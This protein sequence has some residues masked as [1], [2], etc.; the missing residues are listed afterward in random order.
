MSS[1]DPSGPHSASTTVDEVFEPPQIDDGRQLWRIARDSK[2]L[3]LN[4]PYSYV[5]W[6]RDFAATSV[7]ARADGEIRGFV[8]GFARPEEPGTLFVWQVA[9]DAAWRGRALAGRMLAYLA[10]GHRF[11]EATVTPDNTASDRLFSA[12]ARDSGADLR[13]TP[14]LSGELFPGDHQPEELYRIGPLGARHTSGDR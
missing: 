1:G 9:V 4:S 3:D 13:R 14:L 11:V 10:R 12:F 8:T 5:L 6:C 2:T 7:V